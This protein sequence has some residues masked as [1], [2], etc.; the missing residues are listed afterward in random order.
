MRRHFMAKKET[1]SQKQGFFGQRNRIVYLI[2]ITEPILVKVL[3]GCD[4]DL[5][6]IL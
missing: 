6:V 1:L 3:S 5:Y 2:I 4:F